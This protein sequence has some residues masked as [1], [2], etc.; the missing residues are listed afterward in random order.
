MAAVCKT[1]GFGY[2]GSNPGP[3]TASENSLLISPCSGEELVLGCP[4]ASGGNRPATVGPGEYVAKSHTMAVVWPPSPRWAWCIGFRLI[5]ARS[6]R[7]SGTRPCCAET[8]PYRLRRGPVDEHAG[9]RVGLAPGAQPTIGVRTSGQAKQIAALWPIRSTWPPRRRRQPTQ[10]VRQICRTGCVSAGSRLLLVVRVAT[11]SGTC[12]S[13]PRG[14]IIRSGERPSG[15]R[16]T[17]RQMPSEQ[18]HREDDLGY[19]QI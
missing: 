5:G 2:P 1:V 10:G 12:W 7:S 14:R 8:C 16:C 17:T 11:R 3:A 6:G 18:H 9:R 13:V 15:P 19:L 4:V